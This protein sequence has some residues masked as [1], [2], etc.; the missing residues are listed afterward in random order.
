MLNLTNIQILCSSLSFAMQLSETGVAK[1]LM[2]GQ[3]IQNKIHD[4]LSNHL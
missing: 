3:K 2:V 1:L 4:S